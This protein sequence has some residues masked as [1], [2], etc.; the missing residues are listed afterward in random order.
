MERRIST[1]NFWTIK[2][3]EDLKATCSLVFQKDSKI[4]YWRAVADRHNNSGHRGY[5]ERSVVSVRKQA[6][7]M[8]VVARVKKKRSNSPIQKLYDTL[9]SGG[10][11]SS[12][13]VRYGV[14]DSYLSHCRVR[15]RLP[16]KLCYRMLDDAMAM[17]DKWEERDARQ[18]QGIHLDD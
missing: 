10:T 15:G 14:S 6:M 1:N 17:D 3:L 7:L 5:P 13:A 9:R 16:P 18:L 8:G 4:A 2:E 11:M 12:L